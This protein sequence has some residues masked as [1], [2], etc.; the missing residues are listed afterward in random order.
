MLECGVSFQHLGVA[1]ESHVPPASIYCRFRSFCVHCFASL[2]AATDTFI[3]SPDG[4]RLVRLE[5]PEIDKPYKAVSS[6]IDRQEPLCMCGKEI[7]A[8]TSTT[9]RS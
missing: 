5:S 4:K 7:L 3:E 9:L 2:R 8:R 1:G 6:R